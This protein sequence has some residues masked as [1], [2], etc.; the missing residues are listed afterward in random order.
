MKTLITGASSFIGNSILRE[1]HD[2]GS[3][4]K[5]VV[6][7]LKEFETKNSNFNYITIENIGENTDCSTVLSGVDCVVHCATRTHVMNED[8]VDFLVAYRVV[9]VEG[10]RNL[11][12]QAAMAGVWRLIYLSS[13]KVNGEITARNNRF[14]CNDQSNP[15]DPYGVSKWEAEQALHEVAA[16]SGLEVVIVRPPL[17]YGPQVKGNF[18]RLLQWVARGVPF[19][20]GVVRNQRSMIGLDNLIDVDS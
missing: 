19:P 6:R 20:L 18:L 2:R 12:K 10:T 17:V 9:N 4:A 7:S 16:N 11:A 8:V 14:T 15:E 1:M 5:G 3:E 13:V